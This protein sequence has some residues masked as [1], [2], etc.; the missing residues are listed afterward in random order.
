MRL[1]GIPQDSQWNDIDYIDS[2]R[3]FTLNPNTYPP[4]EVSDLVADLH[5]HGQ[6]YVMI[7]DPA[8]GA[9]PLSGGAQDPAAVQG[10]DKNVFIKS[11]S[12]Q[13]LLGWVWPGS[14]YFPDFLHPN[15]TDYWREQLRRWREIVDF[16]GVW[17]DMN[18][19]SNFCNGE[20]PEGCVSQGTD[21]RDKE[22]L[23]TVR[24][25]VDKKPNKKFVADPLACVWAT[26]R[27]DAE[28][29]RRRLLYAPWRLRSMGGKRFDPATVHSSF[30]TRPN[31]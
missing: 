16:D 17:C 26:Q 14:T 29:E 6:R 19:P 4:K 15:A 31:D 2:S 21:A 27:V 3:D 30:G 22:S 28:L 24:G 13:P 12:G 7:I 20:C 18:E 5:A 10:L 23:Q 1:A 8:I 9:S 25:T 11:K